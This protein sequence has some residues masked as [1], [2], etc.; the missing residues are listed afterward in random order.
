VYCNC[1]PRHSAA[2][3]STCLRLGRRDHGVDK[4]LP[5]RFVGLGR[6]LGEAGD[7]REFHLL[8][9]SVVELADV[10]DVAC[11][12]RNCVAFSILG[13]EHLVEAGCERLD[14]LDHRAELLVLLVGHLR[15]NENAEMADTFVQRVDDDVAVGFDFLDR[16]VEVGNPFRRLLRRRDVVAD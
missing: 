11:P 5:E 1:L 9:A 16:V 4:W 15:L 3:R 2:T 12:K 8:L 13:D 6:P 7:G 10:V 14:G